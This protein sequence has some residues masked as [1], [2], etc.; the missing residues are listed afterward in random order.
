MMIVLDAMVLIHLAKLTLLE[1]CCEMFETVL[2]PELVYE[3]T[4]ERGVEAGYPDAVLIQ[5]IVE[6]G[7]VEVKKVGDEELTRRAHKFNVQAGE[8]EALALYWQ[9]NAHL[10]ASDDDNLRSKRVI[11]DLTLMGTPVIILKLRNQN[12]ITEEKFGSSLEHLREM[13]WFSNAV[14]DEVLQKGG[15][16]P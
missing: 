2:I 1:S 9:E 10:L 8:A 3:E 11:L 4:V 15:E 6:K 7:L 14:I 13:G 12:M 5:E 16:K